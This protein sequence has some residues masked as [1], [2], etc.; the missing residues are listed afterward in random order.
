VK[1]RHD[2]PLGVWGD[3]LLGSDDCFPLSKELFNWLMHTPKGHRQPPKPLWEEFDHLLEDGRRKQ[4]RWLAES[5]E[6]NR[7]EKT[8]YRGGLTALVDR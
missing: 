1:P 4:R 7:R 6:R 2:F 3:H 5:K 8:I